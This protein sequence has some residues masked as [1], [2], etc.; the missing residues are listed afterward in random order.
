MTENFFIVFSQVF[1]IFLLILV[2]YICGKSNILKE[3]AVKS[4]SDIILYISTPAAILQAFSTE[5]KT[6]EKSLNLLYI[7]L[8]AVFV[9]V[10]SIF[11]AKLLVRNRDRSTQKVLIFAAVFSNCGFMSFPLQ[12]AILGDIGVFY[13][14]MYVVVFNIFIWSYGAVMMSG[15]KRFIS[16]KKI[17]LNSTVIATVLSIILYLL[18]IRLPELV[19][20][21]VTHL[22]NLNTPLPMIIVGYYLSCAGITRAFT[23]HHIYLI[24][25][26]RLIFI[27]AV[28]LGIMI[29]LNIR[30]VPLA[31]CIIASSAPTAAI[32]AVFAT[33]F[34]RDYTAGVNSVTVTTLL[35]MLTMPLFI[36][37][38]R[39][40]M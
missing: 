23:D 24:T 32:T 3:N 37:L 36:M 6:L 1:S 29:L 31:A 26:L 16:L 12:K 18:Q 5:T 15:D 20:S 9:H 14:A 30:G 35:S 39:Q 40:F 13:G 25:V 21:A 19:G 8:I 2:G 17:L 4:I 33:K 22:S 11:I 10:I 34:G 38:A 28:L 7:F 27:P